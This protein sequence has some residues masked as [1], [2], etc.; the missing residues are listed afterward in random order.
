M[1]MC[2]FNYNIYSCK[3]KGIKVI[4]ERKDMFL[5][6]NVRLFLREHKQN[7]IKGKFIKIWNKCHLNNMLE[8]YNGLLF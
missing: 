3:S 1:G 6:T 7:G 8:G 2:L 4:A 5:L